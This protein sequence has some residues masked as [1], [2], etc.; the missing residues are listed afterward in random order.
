MLRV[1]LLLVLPC[2]NGQGFQSS[3]TPNWGQMGGS[4]ARQERLLESL[5]GRGWTPPPD[6]Q[7]ELATAAQVRRGLTGGDGFGNRFDFGFT[8]EQLIAPGL[9]V[10]QL[11]PVN[12]GGRFGSIRDS[13]A[14]NSLASLPGNMEIPGSLTRGLV[15][16]GLMNP[17]L[18][19]PNLGRLGDPTLQGTGFID[20]TL[21]GRGFQDPT[22]TG[23]GFLDP[24]L[25]GRGLNGPSLA[26]AALSGRPRVPGMVRILPDD[27]LIGSVGPGLG[28]VGLGLGPVGTG[29]GPVGLG[30]GPVG[31]GLGPDGPGLEPVGPGID[32]F[33]SIGPGVI[34]IAG[35]DHH[36]GLDDHHGIEAVKGELVKNKIVTK[37]LKKALK[38]RQREKI[39][40]NKIL[41]SKGGIGDTN[42][43]IIS[44]GDHFHL[45]DKVLKVVGTSRTHHPPPPLQ[46]RRRNNPIKTLVQGLL[47][48]GIGALLGGK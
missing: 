21:Q 32:P 20:P 10:D 12:R 14:A 36:H 3:V 16:R 13:G 17:T 6:V 42:G 26:E 28:P 38:A 29:L 40:K 1:I 35:H 37:K 45:D 8:P 27:G 41:N 33:D 22:L 15:N 44:H 18:V 43:K 2:I 11:L 23:R 25:Q 39:I 48:G 24:T 46:Q 34:G 19:N 30:L 31:L 5:I 7:R 9:T 4:A 47:L